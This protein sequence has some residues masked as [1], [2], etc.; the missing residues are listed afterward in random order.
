[1]KNIESLNNSFDKDK[2]QVRTQVTENE[3]NLV[4]RF[5]C[6]LSVQTLTIVTIVITALI[7]ALIPKA[8]ADEKFISFTD[9]AADG[10]AGIDYRRVTS[11]RNAIIEGYQAAGQFKIDQ[12]VFS[13]LKSHGAPGVVLFDY[14]RDDD[15][16]IYVTNGPGKSNSLYQNQYTD[17]GDLVFVDQAQQA[18]VAAIGSDSTGSCFG[19]IDNDGDQDLLVLAFNAPHSLFENQGDGSFTDI[20]A[21]SHISYKQGAMSCA[22]GDVNGDGLLDIAIANVSNLENVLAF[23]VDPFIYNI[24]NQLFLNVSGNKFKDISEISGIRNLDGIPKGAATM[25]WAVSIV[26]IDHDG[27]QD[28]VFADDQ[29]GMPNTAQGGIDRGYVQVLENDG[30]A[31][32]SARAA[33]TTGEWMGLAINDLNCDGQLDIFASNFGDYGLTLMNPAYQLGDSTSRWLL[34]QAS[35]LFIDPGV[36]DLIATPFGWGAASFDYDNDGD[37]DILSHGGMDVIT[38]VD[39]SNSGVLLRN[40]QCTASFTR[41]TRALEN[42]TNHANRTVQGVAVGDL[43]NDGFVDTVTVSSTNIPDSAPAIPYPV[44][45]GSIFDEDANYLSQFEPINDTYMGWKGEILEE[46]TL[47]V[48]INSADNHNH[49]VAVEVQGSKGILESAKVNRDGIGAVVS[50]K[51]HHG[52]SAMQPILGG[53]SYASQDSLLANF[54]LGRARKGTID[55]LWPG[56]VRNRLYNVRHEERIKFP[57]IPC[58]FDEDWDSPRAYHRCVRHAIFELISKDIISVHFGFRL[59]IS[60]IRAFY[61]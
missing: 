34:G 49:W 8:S 31:Q 2:R 60:A 13:P 28:I 4:I 59:Y 61:M 27:D 50:F 26:D 6:L 54:G 20:S 52:K 55:I 11:K 5:C 39:Q 45:Y 44:A 48:E 53:S 12:L 36:G 16:D 38:A 18:G 30:T 41:D 9:I 46:G 47:S 21:A 57:E 42:S 19:D 33:S 37:P 24:P 1:M 51:P 23:F 22:M 43:N 29:A 32:F 40:N 7:F 10:G 35:G 17:S 58:S 25:S 15:L 3:Y 56:G 14:D